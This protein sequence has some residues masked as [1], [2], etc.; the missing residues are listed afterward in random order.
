M[1]NPPI[2]QFIWVKSRL[3]RFHILHFP[4]PTELFTK[5]TGRHYTR[6]CHTSSENGERGKRRANRVASPWRKCDTPIVARGEWRMGITHE[7]TCGKNSCSAQPRPPPQIKHSEPPP[8]VEEATPCEKQKLCGK[9]FAQEVFSILHFSPVK[10]KNGILNLQRMGPPSA[11]QKK[12]ATSPF[13]E[14]LKMGRKR[15]VTT[16]TKHRFS[17]DI[18]EG[19]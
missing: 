19:Y 8:T 12:H 1:K 6:G 15:G 5:P 18:A 14:D 3:H 17:P 2:S 9:T 11:F 13:S 16:P 10:E 4:N 7:S